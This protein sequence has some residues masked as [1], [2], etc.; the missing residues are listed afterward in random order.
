MRRPFLRVLFL[1][2]LFLRVLFLRIASF[3]RRLTALSLLPLF[4]PVVNLIEG[5]VVLTGRSLRRGRGS[6]TSSSRSTGKA[7]AAR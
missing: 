2:V 3:L 5:F 6:L 7:P 4:L 1:Y